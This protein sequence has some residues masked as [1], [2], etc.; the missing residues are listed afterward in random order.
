MPSVGSAENTLRLSLP[1]AMRTSRPAL[2]GCRNANRTAVG[3]PRELLHE[4]GQRDAKQLEQFVSR[5][6]LNVKNC[7]V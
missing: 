6:A 2:S 4:V 5:S 1:G 3:P 7:S